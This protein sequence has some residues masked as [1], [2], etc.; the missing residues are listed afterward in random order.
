M[1]TVSV[2]TT[3]RPG[4]AGVD[5]NMSLSAFQS[6]YTSEDN[7][8]FYKLVDKQNLKRA[9]KYAWMWNGNKMPSKQQIK[10]KEVE[11][12]LLQT[13][14]LEDDGFKKDRLAIKDKDDRPA[15]PETWKAK[16]NNQL[17]FA[18]DGVEDDMET[19]AQRVQ[20]ESKAPPKAIVYAN[21]RMPQPDIVYKAPLTEPT[22]AQVRDAIAGR[23]SSLY[24]DSST[25]GGGET[26]RVNGYAFVDDEEPEAVAPAPA[27]RIDLG[28][29]DATTNPFQF[30]E[31]RK[32][33]ALHHR[34]VDKLAEKKRNSAHLGLT[35]KVERTPAPRFPSSPR[36]HGGLTPAA[37]RLWGKI[38][39]T[40]RKATDSPFSKVR[41]SPRATPRATPRAKTTGLKNQTT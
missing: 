37:Q 41:A 8:S 10:Q 15:A 7:E 39:S 1:S 17:M 34:I 33:E 16:P 36:V 2:A 14:G 18:P 38:D 11:A 29:G 12:K 26:P 24:T 30:Q 5:T 6:K 32:R 21:T 13:R 40:G 23:R 22:M 4:A 31:Q 25:G 3:Q 28:P 35:G 9:E 27:P 19:V 20:A